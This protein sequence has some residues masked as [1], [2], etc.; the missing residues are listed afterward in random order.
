MSLFKQ[1]DHHMDMA[2]YNVLESLDRQVT[3]RRVPVDDRLAVIRW[4]VSVT[5][6]RVL[7]ASGTVFCLHSTITEM[8][9]TIGL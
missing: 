2:T 9:M 5:F 6:C 4:Q 1:E 3:H 8:L 7:M